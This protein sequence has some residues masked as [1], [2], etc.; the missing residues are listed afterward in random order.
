L[1]AGDAALVTGVSGFL[2]S[3]VAR[4]L[5]ARGLRVRALVR[6]TSQSSNLAGLDCEAVHGDLTDPASLRAALRDIRYLFHVA[7]DY[8]LWAPDS[9]VILRVN[10]GGTRALMQ[11]ALAAGVERIVYTSSVATLKVS[12][13][14]EPVDETAP[15]APHEAIGTYKRSKT[16]AERA[17]EEMILRDRLPAIIVNPS[18]PLGPRDIR[19]TPTGR[20]ILDAARGKIPAFV[21]TGLN[22]AHV[23]DIAE[24]HLLAF[25]RGRIGERYIL[26]GENRSLQ[27]LLVE[28]ASLTGRP[29]PRV[30]LPRGPLFPLAFGAEAVARLTGKEPL[31]TVD[32]LRMSRYRMFFTSAKAERELGYRTRPYQEGVADA[33][34]WFRDAGYLP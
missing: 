15:L 4:A 9:S 31:L 26:G 12:G 20:M 14:T 23:D 13:A 30:R 32:G 34:A 8:R 17:V 33:L 6:P 7:A 28:I 1:R 27:E 11:E 24:G 5:I 19:P 16:L 2:G 18:T 3:A 29:A 21:D 10:V 25:E 22:F